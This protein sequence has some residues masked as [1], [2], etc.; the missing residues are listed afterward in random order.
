[1]K[2]NLV[3]DPEYYSGPE[4]FINFSSKDLDISEILDR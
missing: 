3:D 1:M 2:Y 4:K